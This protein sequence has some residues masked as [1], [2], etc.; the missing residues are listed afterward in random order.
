VEPE[1]QAEWFAGTGYLPVRLSAYDLPAA[2][3][4]LQ[5]YPEYQIPIDAFVG[6][7]STPAK[8]GPRSGAFPTIERTLR[9]ALEAVILGQKS[10]EEALKE[11]AADTTEE[12]QNYNRRVE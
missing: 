5:K 7:P 1:Q 11:A 8:L 6:A 10:P 12:L 9:E 2:H 4:V 3:D